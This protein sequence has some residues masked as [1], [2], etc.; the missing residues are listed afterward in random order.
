LCQSPPG[1]SNGTDFVPSGA[2]ALPKGSYS[3]LPG[4][5]AR[6]RTRNLTTAGPV[7]LPVAN[8]PAKGPQTRPPRGSK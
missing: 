8:P 1:N 2:S 6:P 7:F 5:P 4:P 3:I